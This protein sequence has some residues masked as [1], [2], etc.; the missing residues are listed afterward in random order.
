[1]NKFVKIQIISIIISLED[2]FYNIKFEYRKK[3]YCICKSN[4]NFIQSCILYE[5]EKTLRK[6]KNFR[7]M[8]FKEKTTRNVREK[9]SEKEIDVGRCYVNE[10]LCKRLS[11][12][13]AGVSFCCQKD[14][15]QCLMRKSPFFT[16][17]K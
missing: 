16:L 4:L 5:V 17:K 9:K 8:Q 15:R 13:S 12:V 1:M 14:R 11:G 6:E 2:K 7:G 10:L 3:T